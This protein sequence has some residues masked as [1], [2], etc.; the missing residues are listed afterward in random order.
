MLT[1]RMLA[2]LMT[3]E[4]SGFA[5]LTL[6]A[7]E[8]LGAVDQHLEHED[9]DD[10]AAGHECPPGCLN[11][12][13]AHAA[14]LVVAAPRFEVSFRATTLE[15]EAVAFPSRALVYPGA[16]DLETIYRPPRPRA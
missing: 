3:L 7:C 15:P 13:C 8:L 16:T 4:L 9:C 5:H 10:E 2:V 14:V 11:C 1:L 6:D 12:H